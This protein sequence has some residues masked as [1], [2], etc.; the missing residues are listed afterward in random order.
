MI[1]K[2]TRDEAQSM[3]LSSLASGWREVLILPSLAAL[4]A[5]YLSPADPLL[6][7]GHFPWLVLVPL[8]LGAQQ[9]ALSATL[10]SALLA[11]VGALHQALGGAHDLAS[12]A[13]FVAGCLAV[14]VI[15]GYFHD[16]VA[17]QLAR[18]A[19]QGEQDARQLSRLARAHAILDLSHQRLEDRL[20]AR[21]WSLASAFEDAQR[22]LA[23]ANS[24]LTVGEIVLDVL[25]NH[26]SVQ[27]A[28]LLGVR[29]GAKGGLELEWSRCSSAH[30]LPDT[31]HPLV[32]RAIETRHLVA[33]DPD[34]DEAQDGSVLAVVP[35]CS[36]SARLLGLVVI[37]EMP[38]MAFQPENLKNLAA[39]SAM[40]ADLLE[41][42]FLEPPSS[43]VRPI[44]RELPAHVRSEEV[45]GAAE[46]LEAVDEHEPSWGSG[47]FEGA[48]TGTRHRRSV[49]QS[50]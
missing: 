21:R 18:S 19:Q 31:R 17:A 33:L 28:S 11:G 29:R 35:L 40:L 38:F 26:A 42:R 49:A 44:A 27:R 7:H 3:T 43:E 50:A 14:G 10:G 47:E 41:E 13:G 32:Q 6:L 46:E 2:S 36:V 8:L 34:A 9:G 4:G 37:H 15:A 5:H 45:A 39:L 20:A 23:S 48:R 24:M 25:A 1:S 16:R 12:L 30:G 22:A